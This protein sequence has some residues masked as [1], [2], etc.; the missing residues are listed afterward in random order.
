MTADVSL[1]I[2][3]FLVAGVYNKGRCIRRGTRSGHAGHPLNMEQASL[4]R[5]SGGGARPATNLAQASLQLRNCALPTS[6]RRM[7]FT[8]F[9]R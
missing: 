1:L 6:W 3:D 4:G 9:R 2:G 7:C 5:Q 8:L